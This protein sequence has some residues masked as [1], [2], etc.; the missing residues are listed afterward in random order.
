MDSFFE[1]VFRRLKVSVDTGVIDYSQRLVFAVMTKLFL[2][3]V[4]W[5]PP[6]DHLWTLLGTPIIWSGHPITVPLLLLLLCL[7]LNIFSWISISNKLLSCGAQCGPLQASPGISGRLRASLHHTPD[8][9]ENVRLTGT[10]Q[11]RRIA[12]QIFLMVTI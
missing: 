8:Y 5:L 9:T 10:K 1:L 7:S 12:T 6:I 3:E 4:L 11:T 2:D